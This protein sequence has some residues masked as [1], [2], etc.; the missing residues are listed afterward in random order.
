MSKLKRKK[1]IKEIANDVKQEA[2]EQLQKKA[3]IR[4]DKVISTGST[5]LD[6]AISGKR[7]RGGGIPGGILVEIYG[8]SGS[9]KTT[10]LMEIIT[11][12]QRRG[13]EGRVRDPE[14]RIDQEYAE[15]HD[16]NLSEE[17]FD[18]KRPNTVEELFT[19]LWDWKVKNNNVI[20]V[21]GADSIAALSTELEMENTE[22]DK[23]GQRQAKVFSQSLRKSARLIGESDKLVV[24]TNQLRQGDTG[25]ITSGGK[26]LEYYASLRIRVGQKAMVEK[27]I[28]L[29]SGKTVKKAIG[30]ESSCYIKKSTVDEPYRSF[31]I[32]ILFNYGIDDVR[33][34]LQWYKDMTK[35][36][37]YFCIDKTYQSMEKAIQ[38]IEENK[39]QKKLRST[40][41]N[42]WEEIDAQFTQIRKPK[43]RF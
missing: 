9:G 15:I 19:D 29:K 43:V 18:Y 37:T 17:F 32:Y 25:E 12:A 10:L 35:D 11:S 33:A 26:A 21:F 41:I 4:F 3:Q 2:S 5:G 31:P 24:F 27:E 6:L 36:T 22:G 13:G 20:N 38:Y 1:D 7:V 39:Y 40:I 34:N 14:S 16:V 23:R 8:P 28:K 30:I 42:L